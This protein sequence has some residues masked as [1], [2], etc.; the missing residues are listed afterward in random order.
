[1]NQIEFS[2]HVYNAAINDSTLED[3]L[4]GRDVFLRVT[5]TV[6]IDYSDLIVIN[7]IPVVIV[8]ISSPAGPAQ[9]VLV[10]YR[11]RG[12]E[13]FERVFVHEIEQ[14]RLVFEVPV[15]GSTTI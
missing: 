4:I 10:T 8:S 9:S 15:L 6:S 14:G 5:K 13:L 12:L 1:M 11:D 2:W 7:Y 3:D